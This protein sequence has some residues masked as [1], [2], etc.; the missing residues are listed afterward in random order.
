[1]AG[2]KHEA[3]HAPRH[4]RPMLRV[5]LRN[6]AAHKLRLVLSVLAVVLGT[7]F[8]TGSL[9]FTSTL[10]S[11][12]DGL[13]EQGTA[14]LSAMI[15]PED[16]R[17]AGVPFEVAER[18]LDLPGVEAATP[19]VSGTVVLFNADGTPYQSGG[20][21]S[22]G[23]AWVDPEHSVGDSSWIVDGRAPAGD[24]EVVLPTTV[25]ESAG[26]AIGDTAQV[27][28]T[29][30][31]MLDVRIVGSYA[32]D[33]DIGGYVGVGFSEERARALFTDGE[34]ASDVSVRAEPGVSQ[35]QVRDTI[36]AEF[37]DYTVS[38]GDEV[39]ERLSE[40]LSTIL[41]FVNY[42]FVAFGLIALLVGTFIIYNTFSMLVAQRLRE[43][44]LLRAIGAS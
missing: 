9:V 12:F 3:R 29:G 43:L 44:A 21:P 8:V 34:N 11:T 38:T 17:G 19:G 26:L 42:F 20:A 4:S 5:S 30:Q 32:S 37:P 16:P 36:A 31:G 25:L 24:D 23:L 39:R 6:I 14:D 2:G 7:A 27:Y 10:K 1:M 40:Q 41:D 13:L 22:E 28:T 18:V 33:T 35:E 15:E